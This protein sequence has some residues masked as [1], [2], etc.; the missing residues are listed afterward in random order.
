MGNASLLLSGMAPDAPGRDSLEDIVKASQR[1]GHLTRQLLAYS[2]KARGFQRKVSLSAIVERSRGLI[3]ASVP[4]KVKL[5]LGPAPDLPDVEAD[6]N[7]IQQVLLNLVSNAAEAIGEQPG[8][9]SIRTAAAGGRV[10]LE[11]QDTGCGMDG[12]T[13]ARIF[14]PFFTTK[15]TGRGLGLSAL[16]GIVRSHKG[17][18]EVESTPGQGS[19]FRIWLDAVAPHEAAVPPAEAPAKPDTA[20]TVLVADDEDML[21]RLAHAALEALGYRV[22]EAANGLEAIRQVKGDPSISVV[23]LDLM[24]PVMGGA[25]AIDEILRERPEIKVIV[26]TGYDEGETVERFRDKRVAG[27]LHK[28]YTAKMLVEKIRRVL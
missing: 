24:M 3:E 8:A 15:F 28:P 7:Q 2:G 18:V 1:A 27:Y 25:E 12:E 19:T 26:S 6:P 13:R 14:D 23:L 5:D 17:T 10:L 4:K 11:V 21:R 20:A 9:I 16:A 22:V